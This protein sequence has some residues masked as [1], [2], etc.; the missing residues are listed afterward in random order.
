M[1][2]AWRIFLI[3]TA[4]LISQQTFSQI[5]SVGTP[6]ITNY[7]RAEYKAGSQTWDI[8]QGS[9][10]MMYFANNNGLLEYD[11]I[12]WE[13]YPM[14]NN[15]I[16]R[17]IK[18]D[19]D[20]VIYAGGF[21]EFGYYK[22][23][24][25]GGAKYYSLTHLLPENK[26]NFGDVWNI[27]I[28][29]DGVI[30]QTYS[31]LFFYKNNKVA[32]IQAP[33]SFHFSF[34]VKNELY[35]NDLS[36]GLMRY[37]MGN[38]HTLVGLKELK[39]KEI[40]GIQ[41]YDNKL[42]IALA[43]EGVYSY[44][45]NT[46]DKWETESLQFLM[47]N[48][49]FSAEQLN[50]NL[51]AFGTIQNGLLIC[52][53]EGDQIQHINMED[54]LQNNTILCIEKDELG[55]L[56][57][58]TDLGIDY[59]E[60]NSPLSQLTYSFGL[61][62]GYACITY[63]NNLYLGT[64]KGLFVT[65]FENFKNGGTASDNLNLIEETRGQVWTLQII[66][67]KLFCGHNNGTFI[68]DGNEAELISDVSGGW[69][70]NQ[71]P[72]D[73]LKIIGGNYT[74]LALYQKID[75]QWKFVKQYDNYNESSRIILFDKNSSLWMAHGYKGIFKINFDKEYDSILQVKLFNT[76]NSN[77]TSSSASA[78]DVDNEIIFSDLQRTYSFSSRDNDLIRNDKFNKYLEGFNIR[79]L[80]QDPQGNLWYFTDKKSGVLRLQEDGNYSDI[81]LPFQDI[82][83]KFVKG[84][85][86]VYSLDDENV[87]FGAENGFIH[88]NPSITKN[89]SY[90]FKIYLRSM[91][92]LNEDSIYKVLS[93]GPKQIVLD[94]S[95]ND[96]EFIFS[97]NDF[98]NPDQTVFS[99]FLDGYDTD[100]TEWQSRSSRDFT[101]LNEGNYIFKIK[102]KNIYGT[103]SEVVEIDFK[104]LPPFQRSAVAYFLYG[105][106]FLILL[107]F[108]AWIMKKR[109]ERLKKRNE[110]E[111]LDNFRK[112]EERMER[113]TLEAE[114]QIIRIRNENLR[115]E[116]KQKD[117]ELAN[118]TIQTLHK[119][120]MLI[121]LR[122][123][124][125]KLSA[126]SNDEG[127][128]HEVRHLVRRINKEIDDEN[129]WKIFETHFESVHEEFLKRIKTAFP[130]LTPK[131]LKLC[132]Y[133]R[134]NI[135]SKEIAL[136]MNISVR[137]VEISR[138]RLRKKLNLKREANL[139]DY[140]LSF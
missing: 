18:S 74:G 137:G 136:L 75:N 72:D 100:W 80:K 73:P 32:I 64:N 23:G 11:G 21:N 123:E 38:L 22:I 3:L 9:N 13:V 26:K 91:R 60:L 69:F 126:L 81:S 51:F 139:T 67:E 112:K 62:A 87:F 95:T 107:I 58:G 61:G 16:V 127:Q 103:I 82:N 40:W 129:Q 89:Y 57:L 44:D 90:Q 37:A 10:G 93:G 2:N 28:H 117:K 70:Y 53:S 124:L 30:F 59:L 20:T 130:N 52:N 34:L 45:G 135:S 7:T 122:D 54:G 46:L 12:Y 4:L 102:A 25:M 104:V 76:Q 106:L 49:I 140:I 24:N 92:T 116:M 113:E 43:S 109:F 115:K 118:S 99:T 79:A 108:I 42:L 96:L 119:N 110:K 55:N 5:K 19:N 50:S 68:I 77:L 27:Y 121:A 78:V 131:E 8:E 14:P 133:L 41:S 111:Q 132:A 1:Q 134:M 88:Y 128:K 56:W 66:D 71:A 94:Y 125:K 85:E 17:S 84:F 63:N 48:Q 97:A 31:E 33:S 98:E 83:G 120:E 39:G 101:N 6:F 114:K 29:P 47:E 65:N 138:Y 35:V 15:S 86:F 105:L 36:N